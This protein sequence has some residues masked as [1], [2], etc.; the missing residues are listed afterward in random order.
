M[1]GKK[2]NGW[3]KHRSASTATQ[4]RREQPQHGENEYA[5]Y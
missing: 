5:K 3:S 4:R 1:P 2:G